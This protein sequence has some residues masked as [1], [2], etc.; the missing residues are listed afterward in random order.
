MT[1]VSQDEKRFVIFN[2]S[3][4]NF[5]IGVDRV[6][7]VVNTPGIALVPSEDGLL[8]GI[9]NLRGNVVPVMNAARLLGMDDKDPEDFASVVV[10]ETGNEVVGFLVEKV[11]AVAPLEAEPVPSG[12]TANNVNAEAIEG[13]ARMDEDQ[14]VLLMNVDCLLK[15]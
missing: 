14:L 4:E 8:E 11:V 12:G 5:G 15:K 9:I 10:V 2:L 6:R 3:G 1:V 13:I 7:E